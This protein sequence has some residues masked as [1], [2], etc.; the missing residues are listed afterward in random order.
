AGFAPCATVAIC[1]VPEIVVAGAVP[2]VKVTVLGAAVQLVISSF[3]SAV[4]LRSKGSTPVG[5]P[6]LYRGVIDRQCGAAVA[7]QPSGHVVGV[8][9][10]LASHRISE[11]P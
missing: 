1:G 11:S 9:V 5:T 6:T 3:A 8:G 7:A 2:I 4:T 10:P